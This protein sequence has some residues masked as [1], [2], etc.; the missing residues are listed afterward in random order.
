MSGALVAWRPCAPEHIRWPG[1]PP[2]ATTSISDFDQVPLERSGGEQH[3]WRAL[4][5]VC[6]REIAPRERV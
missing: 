4:S 1:D 6:M 3:R 5:Y 2:L